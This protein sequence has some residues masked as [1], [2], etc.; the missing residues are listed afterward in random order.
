MKT[1]SISRKS[2]AVIA[3]AA[4]I[5]ASCGSDDTVPLTARSSTVSTI[6]T[7]TSTTPETT[8]TVGGTV[9]TMTTTTTMAASTTTETTG[10]ANTATTTATTTTDGVVLAQPAIWPAADVV[11]ATPEE[12]AA[13][14]V[15]TVL[16]VEPLLGEFVGGDS[17]SG[18]IEVFSPGEAAPVSRG[19]L[20][21]RMLPPNDGWF[22]L[23]AVNPNATINSPE[24]YAEVPAGPL[25]VEGVARGHEGTV[26]I[27]A[28][29]AGDADTVFDEVITAGG[30][31]ETPESYSVALDLTGAEAGD[32]ITL[33]VRGDTG[34][35]NDPGDF[36]ATAVV[37]AS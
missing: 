6:A 7:T 26:V 18:E 13:D 29:L 20:A 23:A 31:F 4:I 37:V 8:S 33:L 34:L 9:T 5:G 21:L 3:I 15:R 19:L 36:G 12:A 25:T 1:M 22:V 24:M 28:F 11:F 17:R 14:F 30:V 32:V 10:T 35:E 16:G 27:T 2:F